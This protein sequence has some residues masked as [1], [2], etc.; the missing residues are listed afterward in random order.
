MSNPIATL[1]QFQREH[2]YENSDETRFNYSRQEWDLRLRFVYEYTRDWDAVTAVMRCGYIRDVAT[3]FSKRFLEEPA[4]QKLIDEQKC[5]KWLA[6]GKTDAEKEIFSVLWREANFFG[7]GSSPQARIAATKGLAT[8]LKME[9]AHKE[10]K[11][12][13]LIDSDA[14]KALP[15]HEQEMF[16]TLL[17]KVAN[18]KS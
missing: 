2:A 9:P 4:V 16:V 6:S 10:I 12:P 7:Y 5:P 18:Y 3:E 17:R 1:Q 15:L 14:L 13:Q 11:P 8:L